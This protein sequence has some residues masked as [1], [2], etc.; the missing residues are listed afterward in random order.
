[1]VPL[2]LLIGVGMMS[3]IVSIRARSRGCGFGASVVRA[4]ERIAFLGCALSVCLTSSC[5]AASEEPSDLRFVVGEPRLLTV[6]PGVWEG[7]FFVLKRAPNDYLGYATR[8]GR[9]TL[10]RGSSVGD[11]QPTD[12]IVLAPPQ[13]LHRF[14]PK[15]TADWSRHFNTCGT[16]LRYAIRTDDSY[17]GWYHAE[18]DCD[19]RNHGQTFASTGLAASR[20]GEAFHDLLGHPLV[21][22]P[23][24][25]P[26]VGAMY[27]IAEVTGVEEGG[28]VWLFCNYLDPASRQSQNLI[29]LRVRPDRAANPE[30]YE[31]YLDG[32]FVPMAEKPGA[33]SRVKRSDGLSIISPGYDDAQKAFFFVNSGSPYGSS[34][35]LDFTTDA[36]PVSIRSLPVPLLPASAELSAS[37]RHRR[38]AFMG[39]ASIVGPEGGNHFSSRFFLFYT[40]VPTGGRPTE[41][42]IVSREVTVEPRAPGEP[43]VE[44]TL[45]EYGNAAGVRFV[46]TQPP[47]AGDF[48]FITN[49]GKLITS[50]AGGAAAL[51][52]CYQPTKSGK[53]RLILRR[54]TCLSGETNN[55]ILGYIYTFAKGVNQPLREFY[56]CYSPDTNTY[57]YGSRHSCS[58]KPYPALLGFMIAQPEI[59]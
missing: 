8:N 30:Q 25:S 33:Y 31:K 21:P 6:E 13:T 2:S 54:G 53:E 26:R 40:Y 44:L 34:I 42:T 27:G 20:D 36:V 58:G 17:L 7:N 1:M 46:S 19:Y 22:Q 45:S 55:G 41:R 49:L 5:N 23:L 59:R 39:N 51:L 3:L 14:D 35:R 16:W 24:M 28:Y 50:P 15:D 10:F 37:G 29:L 43:Q 12:Q 47:I 52:S 56:R 38:G 9:T 11:L 18:T 57:I 32:R 48:H 4:I